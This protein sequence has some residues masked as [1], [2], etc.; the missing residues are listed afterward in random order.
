VK[1]QH[2]FTLVS[3][4]ISVTLVAVNS[5]IVSA[6]FNQNNIASD[7]V[8]NNSSTMN[9][10]QIDAF[11]NSF[12]SSCISTNH[13]FA[14]PSLNGY[15]P[16]QGYLYGGLVSA[17]TVI[18]TAAQAY[19][20]NPQVLLATLQKEQSLVSGSAGCH[21][22]TPPNQDPCPNPPY[23][24]SGPCVTACQYSGGCVYIAV[25]YD[26]PYYCVAG[27]TGF[28]KQIIKA[29][30]KLKFVQQ[31]SLGNY[32]W[33][34]QKPG[35][36]NSDDPA[37][38]YEGYMTQ[39][40]LKRNAS[41]AA[42]SYDGYRPV[43]N[44]SLSVHLDSGATASL[45]S[46]TPFTSGNQHFLS[47]FE[48]WFGPTIAT[49]SIALEKD[50]GSPVSL[51]FNQNG[52]LEFMGIAGNDSIYHKR[53]TAASSTTWSG[54]TPIDG[55]L[56]NITAET[57]VN[58]RIQLI[59]AAAN[60]NIY[61]SLQT[62]NNSIDWSNW[63]QMDGALTSAALTRNYSGS[64]ELVGIAPN[65]AIYN[66]RQSDTSSGDWSGWTQIPGA[67]RNITAESNNDGRI[68]LVGVASN[69]SIY[70]TSQTAANSTTWSGWTQMDGGLA[71]VA[72]ARNN[73]G[74][75]EIFGTA[76]NGAIYHKRQTAANSTTWSGWTQ[77]PGALRNITAESNNDGR[78]QLVGVA[79]NG[80][81]YTTSQTAANSTTWSGWTQM[82]GALRK[83]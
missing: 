19:D 4:V 31:R 21:Y 83:Y 66:K 48:G 3:I 40:T 70:T 7:F 27:S 23:G 51:V 60:G 71:T 63:T 65:G 38:D 53:Q 39:G 76:S 44:G 36:D 13:G 30:W 32:N 22:E 46:Y 6:S 10:A 11:L 35:W 50:A 52:Q 68:Q 33:N 18:A 45:Y 74:T 79:S 81:I 64:L 9:S 8:F 61:S 34:I 82:D 67:L 56:R 28:S 37:T 54:W 47:L 24:K 15:N 14:T 57:N 2:F 55:G 17:G 41:S 26:C 78:I 43:N 25:G 29:A 77:I 80:S 59:G 75:L 16:A 73:D 1:K 69:G 5:N 20:L 42:L 58:G 72:L 62:A 12:P 49:A